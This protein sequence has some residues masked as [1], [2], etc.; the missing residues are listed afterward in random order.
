MEL[1]GKRLLL[2]G[3]SAYS[4][5]LAKYARKSQFEMIAV[6]NVEN[7]AYKLIANKSYMIDTH[8]VDVVADIAR[9]EK[10]DGIFVGALEANIVPAISVAEKTG[11]YFYTD[12]YLWNLLSNKGSFKKLMM[13]HGIGVT[14]EF[15]ISLDSFDENIKFVKFPV[16]VKPVDGSGAKGISVCYNEDEL[17]KGLNIACNTSWTKKAIVEKYITGMDDMFIHY[18]VVDGEVSLSCTF[19]RNLNYSQGGFTGMAVAYNYPSIYTRQYVDKIDQKMKMAFKDA[20]IVNGA[21]N[22]QCFTDGS[23]FYFYEAGYRLGGEQMYFF[24][25]KLT[26]INV[27]NL[28]V[29]QALT[30]KMSDNKDILKLDNPYF[31]KPCLSYYIPL[32]PGMIRKMD[33]LDQI[34]QLDGVLNVTQFCYVGDEI[35]KDGSLGQVCMRMHLMRDTV[36]ELGKLVDKVNSIL[37][38]RNENDEDMML[39][40]FDLTKVPFY[41][42]YDKMGTK[43]R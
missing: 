37:D 30:G 36:E 28:L 12:R 13:E 29:N 40:K 35:K 41:V 33:G 3:G 23:N 39:E 18:T 1:K 6:G 2:M 43:E 20:G 25:E 17:R 22:I 34:R 7:A 11:L 19:D 32:K 31:S 14:E 42:E 15:N 9:K 5:S 10:C 24:T 8:D 26:G 4:Q 38:I 21:I 16:I 27:F